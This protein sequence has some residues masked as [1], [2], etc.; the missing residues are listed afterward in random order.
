MRRGVDGREAATAAARGA[1]ERERIHSEQ[2]RLGLFI[3]THCV[4]LLGLLIR[5]I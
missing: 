1:E 3:A 2:L 5:C 4:F